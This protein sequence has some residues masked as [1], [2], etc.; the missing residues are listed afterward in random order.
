MSAD[1]PALRSRARTLARKAVPPLRRLEDER[2]ELREQRSDLRAKLTAAEGT[3]H[4]LEGLVAELQGE[5]ASGGATSP[6]RR[7]EPLQ[8]LFVVTYGRS[9]STLLQGILDSTPGYLIRGE[10]RDALYRLYQY[11]NQLTRAKQQ[12]SKGALLEP[13]DAWF[14]I[15]GY[16]A[17][18]AVAAMRSLVLRTLLRPEPD[19]RVTGFKEIRWWH[20]D[21]RHYLDFLGRLFPGARFIVNVRDHDAVSKSKWWA[22]NPDALER[23]ARYERQLDEMAEYLG[24]TVYRVNFDEFVADHEVLAGLF[25]WLGEPFDRA[26]VDA[27]MA[28]KHSS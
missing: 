2:R 11:Q 7:T 8:Y 22:R 17:D 15:D 1:H 24:D 5:L 25:D 3:R 23:L 13:K 9:G 4:R 18:A 6:D 19:T 28:I 26:R 12:W 21:W 20:E 10:N 14:G 16:E 27:T